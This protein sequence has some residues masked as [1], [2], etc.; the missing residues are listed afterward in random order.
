[1]TE[2]FCVAESPAL[3]VASPDVSPLR[4]SSLSGARNVA[5]E[6]PEANGLTLGGIAPARKNR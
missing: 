6:N 3:R 4:V 1:M 2:K 5:L